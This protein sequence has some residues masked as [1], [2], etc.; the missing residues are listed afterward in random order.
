M[1]T[2]SSS[3]K[4]F[5]AD[6]LAFGMVIMLAMTVI[7]RG[8]GF[9]RG[10]WFCRLLDDSVL[11]QWSMAYDFIVMVT[12]IMLLGVPGSL[13]RYAELYRTRGHLPAFVGRLLSATA[14]LGCIFFG[15]LLC[16]P[17]QV[18]WLVFLDPQST[19][20]VVSI[21]IAMLA[22]VAFN[23]V[24]QLVSSLRQVRVGSVMQ[25]TQSVGF[26]LFS[27]AWLY[28][29][30]GVGGLIGTYAAATLLAMIPGLL[31]LSAGWRGLP[32]ATQS[33]EPAPMW[34]RML[35]YAAA[36]WAMNVL[37]NLFM[38]SDRYMILHLLSVGDLD[39]QAAIGQYH[40]SR[41]VPLLLM[42]LAT[43]VAG[44]L[45]PYMTA[46]WEAGKKVAVRQTLQRILFG[47]SVAFTLGAGIALWAAPWFF[48]EVL[49][50]RYTD[51]LRLMPMTFVFAIWY[52]L[53]T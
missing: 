43:M 37:M 34:R 40:S 3:S 17:E 38:L 19:S 35:P 14:L 51:G 8:V 29:G 30:G 2:P 18:G 6:S 21:G 47:L 31:S 27:V 48:N 16:F 25:F 49:E 9:F 13:P 50:N 20:L 46:D 33:F 36:L 53:V 12:P 1:P 11:G 28:V 5:V 32:T 26:T 45:L 22:T 42:S 39:G 23:F 10:I 7:Q 24:Y 52:S 4:S 41:I 44:V 15:L